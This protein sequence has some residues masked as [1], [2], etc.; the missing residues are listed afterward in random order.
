MVESPDHINRCLHW[1]V[2][3]KNLERIADHATTLAEYVI[4]FCEARDI[5][6]T[7]RSPQIAAAWET[8]PATTLTR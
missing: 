7:S 2:V 5:R 1:L 3:A 8:Q 6:L 4:Y